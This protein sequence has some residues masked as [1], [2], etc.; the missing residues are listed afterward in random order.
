M[1]NFY[2]VLLI[3]VTF[4]IHRFRIF[5]IKKI[6]REIIGER[7]KGTLKIPTRRT[8]K[9][10]YIKLI[11]NNILKLE[12]RKDFSSSLY[13]SEMI[14]DKCKGKIF[15]IRIKYFTRYPIYF[16]TYNNI[17]LIGNSRASKYLT[18]LIK[19]KDENALRFKAGYDSISEELFHN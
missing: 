15:M 13:K 6:V 11:G 17:L 16:F 19:A 8:I 5:V 4:M 9:S 2:V 1:I 14:L 12:D 10:I 18:K 7:V 3:L